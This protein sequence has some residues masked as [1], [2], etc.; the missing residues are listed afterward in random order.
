MRRQAV[1]EPENQER[2]GELGRRRL[3]GIGGSRWRLP[4]AD[5]HGHRVTSS[6]GILNGAERV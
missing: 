3:P 6:Q 5:G 2:L 4:P 1:Q